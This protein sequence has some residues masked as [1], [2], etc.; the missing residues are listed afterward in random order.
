MIDVPWVFDSL[1]EAGEFG[2]HLFGMTSLN[3]VEI[4]EAM[5]REIGFDIEDGLPHL[6]WTLRRMVAE[7]R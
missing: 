1:E 7:A 5:D 2:R 4:A 6:R 3:A